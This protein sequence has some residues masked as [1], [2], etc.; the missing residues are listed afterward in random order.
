MSYDARAIANYFLDLSAE[1]RKPITP[2]K[3][4]KLVYFTHGWNLAIKHEPL[5]NERIEAWKFGPVIPSLYQAFKSVGAGA[6]TEKANDISFDPQ[7]NWKIREP[8][9]DTNLFSSQEQDVFT[10]SL[11]KRVWNVYGKFTGE[12][13]SR[14][15]HEP[16]SPWA[17]T[18]ETFGDIKNVDIPDDLIE[19]YFTALAA[20]K[21]QP[22][23]E[24]V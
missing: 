3:M 11:L 9:I 20:S 15:T 10:K 8:T 16:G 6:I 17:T 7:G 12:Q 14:M 13:L 18:R 21:R 24:S 22:A 5:L 1:E 19:K 23:H 4:Q 2:L